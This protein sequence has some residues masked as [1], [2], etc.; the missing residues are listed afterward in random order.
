MLLEFRVKNFRSIKDEQVFSLVAN[1]DK[2]HLDTNVII[3]NNAAAP[4]VLRSAVIYG[5]N[6]SGKTNLI[7][8]LH[9]MKLVVFESATLVQPN[10]SY[11]FQAFQLDAATANQPVEFEITFLLEGDRYQYGFVLAQKQVCEEW[12]LA[13]KAA[14]PQLWFSRKFNIESDRYTYEFGPYFKGQKKL[15]QDS[16]RPNAL[17][18]STSAQLNSEQLSPI[19]NWICNN[20]VILPTL[21]LPLDSSIEMLKCDESKPLLQKFLT[22]ADISISDI[23]L[24]SQPGFHHNIHF[25]IDSG[26]VSATKTETTLPVLKFRHETDKGSAVLDLSEESLGTQRLFALAGSVL[27]ILKTGR[28][29]VVDELNSS[30]HPHLVQ[31]LISFFHDPE[32]NSK[33][34]QLIFS[35]HDTSLLG[36]KIFRRDQIWLVDKNHEQATQLTP[37]SDF[38]P[39]KQ[40]AI[41]SGYLTGR[42][43]AIPF[44]KDFRF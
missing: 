35:T 37:L 38:S 22:S 18:L 42:Y 11:N 21:E 39:R 5:P 27:D 36:K 2:A 7:K 19:F 17:F 23:I 32:I 8:A 33:G 26:E 13:Y 12:L 9:Y 3:T 16:T 4:K 29:L 43:G 28:V 31:R 34:A 15:W 30:L 44:F 14:K 1:K 40:E 25:K 6:A 10:Q 41:D 24:E 20:L